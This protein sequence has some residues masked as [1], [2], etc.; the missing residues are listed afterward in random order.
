MQTYLKN[1]M[2]PVQTFTAGTTVVLLLVLALCLGATPAKAAGP[3]RPIVVSGPP[4]QL[5]ALTSGGW[6]GSQEPVGGT[7]VIGVNGNVLIGDGYT[8]NFLQI[9][10]SGSDTVLASGVGA[11]NAALDSYGN[12]YFGGNYNANVYKIPY[13]AATGQYVGWTT[14]PTATCLGGNQDTAPCLFAPAVSTLMGTLAGSGAAGY[15][16]MAFDGQGNFFF[17]TNTLPGTNP[18]AIYECNVACIA[19]SSAT[20]VLIYADTQPVG[21]FAIDPWG[22]LF[23]VDGNNSKG[24]AT[25]LSEVPLT[26]GTYASSATVLES[27]TNAAGYGNGISGL[28]ISGTGTL[29]FSTNADGIFAIPNTQSDGPGVDDI[30]M[31]ATQGGKGVAIDSSGNLYGIPYNGGDVVSFIP[32]GSLSLGAE[33][34]GTAATAVNATAID[35]AA[36]CTPTL[37]LSV[38]ESGVSSSEFT[39]TAGTTC[40]TTFGASNGTFA[41]GPLT[42]AAFSSFGVT[43]NFTPTAAG[44][45]NAALSIKDSAN[46]GS[47]TMAL[48]G[49]GQSAWANLDPGVSTAFSTGFTSPASVVADPAGDVFVADSGAGAVYEIAHGT[50]T[51]TSIGSGFVTPDALAFDANGDLFIGDDGL[52]GV[53]EI[54]NTGTTGAFAAGT[55]LTAVSAT[56]LFDGMALSSAAGLAVGPNGT[57][58]I[59]DTDNKRV[60]FWDPITGQAG[61]TLATTANGITSPM[62]LAVDSSNNLYVADSSLDEVLVFWSVG[63]ISTVTPPNVTEAVGVAVDA[64]GSVLVADAASGNIVR[65]PDLGG[66]LTPASAVT[67]EMVSPQASSL[68]IDSQGDIYVPS[69]SGKAAYAIQRTAASIDFGTVQNGLTNSGTVYL[70]N[71]GNAAATL[72]TPVV[73]EPANTMFTLAPGTTNP[74]SSGSSGPAGA[75]CQFT[76]TFAPIVGTSDGVQTGQA[77]VNIATPALALTVNMTGTASQSSILAQKI[78]GF[79]PPA[80]LEAGQQIMLSATGGDSGNPIVFSIDAASPCFACATISGNTLTAASAGGIIVDANQAG[81]T[82]NGKQYAAATQVQA[83]I[84]INNNVVAT[85]VPALLM[86]QQSWLAGLPGGGVFA[87]DS[88]AGTSFGVNPQGNVLMGTS[89]GDSVA[90]FN[91]QSGTWT[92]LGSYGKYNNTGGVAVDGAGN[93]YIGALYSNIIAM[94]PYNNGAYSAVTDASSGTPPANCSS[95][96]TSE[97][98]VGPVAAT[99]GIGG[100]SAMAFDSAGDLFIGTDDQGN[101]PWS[102]WECT[103]ACLST[104]TPAPVMLFQEPAGNNSSTTVG[105]YYTGALALDPW[106]NLFFTDSLL[107]DQS[108]NASKSVSSDLYYLPTSSGAGFGGVTTGYAAAPTLL[109]TF[110]DKTPGGYDDVLDAAAV[111]SD[112]TVYYATQYDG[113]FAIP[114]SQTGGPVTANQYAVSGQGAKDI[115]LDAH[116]NIFYASYYGA[117][118]GDTLGEIL[119]TNNLVTP[120]AQYDGAPVTAS[121]NVVD[122]AF[123]CGTAATIAVASSDAQFSATAGTT[124]STIAVSSG[125]GTLSN[126]IAS[127][128]GYSA[129]ITFTATKPN[130]QN[131]TL[132]LSDTSNGGVGT[133]AVS[134]YALTTPQA[135]TFTAPASTSFTFAPAET[136]IVSVTNGGS[137]NPVAFTADSSS[138]GAGTFSSTTVTGTTSSAVLTITQAGSIVIDANEA[139]GLTNGTYYDAAQQVQLTLT[140]G[141]AAQAIVFPQPLSPV[142]YAANPSTTVTLSANGGASANPVVFTVDTTSTGAGT[143]SDS[144][145]SNGTSTATLTVSGAG[146]IV[147]DANQAADVNYAVASQVQQTIVV[148]QAAQTITYIPLTQPFHYIATGVTLP[149]MATGG[150]SDSPIVFTV[151]KSSTM[152]GTFSVS[153]VS[154]ATSSATLTIPAQTNT[155]GTIVIDATQ[156]GNTNYSAAQQ[157]QETINVLS[158][159]PIQTITFAVPQTQV[160][161]T[162]LTLTATASSGFPV[163]YT[164]STA[165]VC[166]VSNSTATFASVTSAGTCTI[167]ASQP[168]D[169]QY[170]AAALPVTVSFTVNPPGQTPAMNL[171]LSLSSLTLQSGTVGLTEITVTSQNNFTGSVAFACSGLPAGYTC[172]FN[173]NPI[174]VAEG[175]S[176]STALSISGSATAAVQHNNSPLFPAATLAVAICLIGFKKRNRLQ[177]LMLFV[178]SFAALGLFTACGGSTATTTKATTSSVTITATSGTMTQSA[179]LTVTVE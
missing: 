147:I 114:N 23:F 19:S 125:N 124:C 155:S 166:T 68:W 54:V 6:D 3:A 145:V 176:V 121:A 170:F 73:T 78:T 100:V 115:E 118:G 97:C 119:T 132:A 20:P 75:T 161:G 160:G 74:C 26:S 95:S 172:T 55:Q 18:N 21:A 33:P 177:L 37:A 123:G 66:T 171:N 82:A 80:T 164:S 44:E 113:I 58:Y 156:P 179:T 143:I 138:T 81:G 92:K 165:S 101:N 86:N 8:S 48:T 25:N 109:Q 13:N 22:N 151:D 139:G 144:T 32:V 104:G 71:A 105:Q 28:A 52:P 64:S 38:T 43:A 103:A 9:A 16:G 136:V 158:P 91:V 29:Y 77:T 85:G 39:A 5:G 2:S 142:T 27:Y 35:N 98:V 69:A 126:P 84:T 47:G 140:V 7:F 87:Q 149:I 42:A 67:V 62:G 157:T 46:N 137:N 148:N 120:N 14:A 79:T 112:G 57:L 61:V 133:A 93:L 56:T 129:T 24:K 102:I 153:T 99:A 117:D 116:G 36:P 49:V 50:T 34:V 135:L 134:G 45:R 59:S 88:A 127:A 53:E 4:T 169:N 122:N 108:T 152:T 174:T 76:A 30:Y 178:V 63:G 65:I 51:P 168:G 131:A 1:L 90:L 10:P 175:G 89:Y 141:Q 17:E 12:V 159:L 154:G 111:G 110:T 94:V 167:T 150:G 96:S 60:V 41:S 173:P 70:S 40:S 83:T 106:G 128:S 31:V 11:S 130:S 146:N 163:V 72:A 162:T 107:L 15:A